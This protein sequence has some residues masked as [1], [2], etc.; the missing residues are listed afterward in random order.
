MKWRTE[1]SV[2]R[3]DVEINHATSMIM[4]GSCFTDEIGMRLRRELFDAEVNPSG[5]LFNPEV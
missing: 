5:I 1:I 4:L 3:L 2:P